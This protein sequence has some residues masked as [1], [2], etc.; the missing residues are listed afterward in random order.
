MNKLIP[1]LD[2]KAHDNRHTQLNM[3]KKML[4][5]TKVGWVSHIIHII[6]AQYTLKTGLTNYKERVKEDVTKELTQ[7]HVLKTFPKWRKT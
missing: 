3:Y 7:L 2:R 5:I 6:M 1:T 4:K